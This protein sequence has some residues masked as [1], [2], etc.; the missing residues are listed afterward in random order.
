MKSDTKRSQRDYSLA[1]KL[2][3]VDHVVRAPDRSYRYQDSAL[4]STAATA[5][6]EAGPFYEEAL[7]ERQGL[8]SFHAS[9]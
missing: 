6:C 9:S 3:V 1:F 8:F 5:R 7:V 2:A 4:G